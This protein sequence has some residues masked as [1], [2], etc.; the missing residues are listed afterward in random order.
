VAQVTDLAKEG[1]G[2]E[3]FNSALETGV[4][5]L[6]VLNAAHPKAFDLSH[7][8]WFDHLVVHTADV[9][10]PVSLHPDVPQRTGELLVR[11]RLIDGGVAL[12][13][14]MHLVEV[15]ADQAGIA[16]RASDEAPAFVELMRTKYS[17][18]LIA[19]ARWLAEHVLTLPSAELE[20]L[21]AERIGRW[22]VEFQAEGRAP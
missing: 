7:L 13:R 16:Y 19:R 9:G 2:S 15:I 1:A 21:I 17:K 8:T 4:R 11:R 5:A 14:R 10:G 3:L 18:E 20:R 12:M 22:A 6:V